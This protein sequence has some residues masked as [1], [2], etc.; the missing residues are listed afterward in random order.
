MDNISAYAVPGVVEYETESS[1][2][3][4]V[5]ILYGYNPNRVRRGDKSRKRDYVEI[6]QITI[7]LILLKF[8]CSY[9]TA[10]AYFGK[11]HATAFHSLKT[12][13]NLLDTSPA[14]KRKNDNLFFGLKWPKIVERCK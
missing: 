10:G 14:F 9:A 13:K 3:K 2:F 11:D 12:V 1:I 5:C 8:K 4:R 7:T 6:R